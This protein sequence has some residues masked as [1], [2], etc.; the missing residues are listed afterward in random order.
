MDQVMRDK[1]VDIHARVTFLVECTTTIEE[2]FSL[3][4]QGS[5][6]LCSILSTVAKDLSNVIVD[7]EG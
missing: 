3:S 1:L 2:G 6:G 4:A 7:N 5:D